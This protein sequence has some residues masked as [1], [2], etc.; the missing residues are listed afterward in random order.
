MPA[1]QTKAD[2]FQPIAKAQ[3][4][5]HLALAGPAAFNAPSPVHDL[6]ALL[7]AAYMPEP[8]VEKWPSSRRLLFLGG[9]V[10][11]SWSVLLFGLKTLFG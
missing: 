10:V 7:E 1:L 3:D 11:S 5:S 6:Q 2:L 4:V 8:E 9:A